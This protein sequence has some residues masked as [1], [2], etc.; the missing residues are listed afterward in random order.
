MTQFTK[1]VL[2][3]STKRQLLTTIAVHSVGD[4]DACTDMK[5]E[6]DQPFNCWFAKKFLKGDGSRD[7]CTYLF[8]R[9]QEC[10]QKAIKEKEIPIEGLE[11]MGMAKKSRKTLLDLDSHLEN[12]FLK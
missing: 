3:S 8:K 4:A 6:W 2:K 11:F 9:Y 12:R 5:H 10:V 1:V 7:Q